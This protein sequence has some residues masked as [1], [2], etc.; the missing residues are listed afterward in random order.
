MRIRDRVL[1]IRKPVLGND[2]MFYELILSIP[3][4]ISKAKLGH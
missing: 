3:Y 1:L 2:E 4:V